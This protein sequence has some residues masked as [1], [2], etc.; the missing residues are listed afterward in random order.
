MSILT[1]K[2]LAVLMVGSTHYVDTG[3]GTD[4]VIYYPTKTEVHMA[5]PNGG[6]IWHGTYEIGSEGYFVRWN[7]GPKGNWKI[8]YQPGK[9]TYIGPDG[10]AAG[11]ITRIVPGDPENTAKK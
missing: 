3:K 8:D 11:T 9:F 4:A 10:N 7:N 2:V 6:P 5:L 1:A